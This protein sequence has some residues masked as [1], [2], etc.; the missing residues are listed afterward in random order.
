MVAPLR[1]K[2]SIFPSAVMATLM[3]TNGRSIF[4]LY[5]HFPQ[6]PNDV[7]EMTAAYD[8]GRLAPHTVST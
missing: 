8:F 7:D 3:K 2:V 6:C 4:Q 1:A 5:V